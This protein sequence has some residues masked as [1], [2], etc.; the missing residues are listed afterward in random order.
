M[1]AKSWFPIYFIFRFHY[2]YYLDTDPG[3]PEFTPPGVVSLTKVEQPILGNGA[4][5]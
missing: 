4:E 2:A 3:Q 1:Y 5:T